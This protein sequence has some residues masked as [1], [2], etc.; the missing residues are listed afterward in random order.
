MHTYEWFNS[1]MQ[2]QRKL[3]LIIYHLRNTIYKANLNYVIK[4]ASFVV[5]P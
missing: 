5:L 3:A 1:T 4:S 2:P